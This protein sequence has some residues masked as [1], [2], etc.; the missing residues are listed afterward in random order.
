MERQRIDD[1]H[2]V[3]RYLAGQLDDPEVAAFEKHYADHP[4][5]VREIERTLRLKEGLAVLKERGELDALLRPRPAW[6]PALA[7]AAGL[8]MLVV[9]VLLWV[10][11]A[12]VGPIA[13]TIAALGE[14]NGQP[15]QVVSTYVLARTRGAAPT[16]AVALPKDGGALE[17]RMIPSSRA[18]SSDFRVTIAQLDAA[19]AAAP[20]AETRASQSSE[21]GFVTAYLDSSRLS[22]GRYRIELAPERPEPLGAPADRF[23]L[24][25]Q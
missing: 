21:D 20:L 18:K 12:T 4:D 10:G 17:L 2:I 15:L 19:D 7:L 25:L 23:I 16:I 3:A 14:R 9:G 5:V 6:K 8:A 22:R 11:Q 1:E 13:G 24:E